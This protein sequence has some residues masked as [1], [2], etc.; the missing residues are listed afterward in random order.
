[1]TEGPRDSTRL[2][3]LVLELIAKKKIEEAEQLCAHIERGGVVPDAVVAP[4]TGSRWLE[5]VAFAYLLVLTVAA[6]LLVGSG[7]SGTPRRPGASVASDTTTALVTE[8]RR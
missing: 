3:H 7:S 2:A 8:P 1:V 5:A 6:L 4:R